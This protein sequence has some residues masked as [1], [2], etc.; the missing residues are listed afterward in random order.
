MSTDDLD[1]LRQDV[2]NARRTLNKSF[3]E[4]VNQQT[5]RRAEMEVAEDYHVDLELAKAKYQ[6]KVERE[7]SGFALEH[8]SE[9]ANSM[10]QLP[11]QPAYLV[12]LCD[13]VTNAI[14]HTVIWSSPEWEQSRILG[15]YVSYVALSVKDTAFSAATTRLVQIALAHLRHIAIVTSA[16][17]AQ[18]LAVIKQNP[19]TLRYAR[20]FEYANTSVLTQLAF[21]IDDIC[22]IEPVPVGARF[23]K[24]LVSLLPKLQKL[25]PDVEPIACP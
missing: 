24:L 9:F 12:V 3:I 19:N 11:N 21:V 17:D 22:G 7:Q 18:L 8:K 20:L 4:K 6:A 25:F 1:K 23:K 16:V 13:P 10:R 15:D 14:K 5:N 2:D